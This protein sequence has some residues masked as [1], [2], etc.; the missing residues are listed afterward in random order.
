MSR[1]SHVARLERLKRQL[2][3]EPEIRVTGPAW[4]YEMV[5]QR[6]LSRQELAAL[7]AMDLRDAVA[8]LRPRAPSEDAS[9][10][11]P[12]LRYSGPGQS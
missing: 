7:S 4:L 3:G 1:I 5:A 12:P 9:P 10:S 6:P 11:A 8:R 2:R